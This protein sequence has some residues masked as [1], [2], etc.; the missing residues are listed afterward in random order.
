LYT[1]KVSNI[2]EDRHLQ[3]VFSLYNSYSNKQIEDALKEKGFEERDLMDL[4]SSQLDLLKNF[5]KT[6]NYRQKIRISSTPAN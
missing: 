4:N 2:I 5:M 6:E 1:L 3:R